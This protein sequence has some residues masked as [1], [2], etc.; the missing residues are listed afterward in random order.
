[1]E[2]SNIRNPRLF[3]RHVE[4]LIYEAK[5]V[6]PDNEFIIMDE[7]G[8]RGLRQGP[9]EIIIEV[10][11][12]DCVL[13]KLLSDDHCQIERLTMGSKITVH[14]VVFEGED[15]EIMTKLINKQFNTRKAGPGSLWVETSSCTSCA[16]F[17]SSL[18]KILGSRTLCDERIQY[19][20][21]LPSIRDLRKLETRMKSAGIEYEIMRVVPYVHKEM[22]ERQREILSIAFNSGYFD[23]DSRM[24]LT[25]LAEMIGISPSSL[26]EILRRSLKKSVDY[27]F[28]HLP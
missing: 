18:S 20:T 7:K 24:S 19:R 4:Y 13:A 14:K 11:R 8:I 17:S 28:D 21:L 26:S 5:D 25:N 22:T 10:V 27:Y 23:Q 6:L 15:H 2:R 3:W 1:M 16:F 9:V 12:R